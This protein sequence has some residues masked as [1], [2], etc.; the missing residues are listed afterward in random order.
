VA[1]DRRCWRLL[2]AL[3]ALAALAAIYIVAVLVSTTTTRTAVP[4]AQHPDFSGMW[5]SPGMEF[6]TMVEANRPKFTAAA[7]ANLAWYNAHYD[8]VKDD[9]T[10]VC[11]L[12]GMPWTILLRPRNYPVEIFQTTERISVF[13]ELYDT[14]RNIFLNRTA[15]PE[16]VPPSGNG[17]SI[18]HWERDA[19]VIDTGALTGLNPI[20]PYQRSTAARITERWTLRKH[21]SLGQVLHVEVT[22]NDPEVYAEPGHGEAQIRPPLVK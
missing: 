11:L 10:R 7:A 8:P 6:V 19:P 14:H 16:D 5:E 12:K 22:V 15:V 21:Q 17:Y 4:T 1:V 13:F 9:P 18:G 20:G 2:T 3:A